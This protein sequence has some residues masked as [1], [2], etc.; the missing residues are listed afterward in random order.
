LRLPGQQRGCLRHIPLE[1]L[2]EEILDEA[3]D[4]N[5]KAAVMASRAAA[6]HMFRRG[7]ARS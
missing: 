7:K 1:E 5:V 4:V 3:F 2:S 6:P